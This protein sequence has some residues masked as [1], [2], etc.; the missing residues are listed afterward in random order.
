MRSDAR[1]NVSAEQTHPRTQRETHFVPWDSYG[2]QIVQALCGE[3]VRRHVDHSNDP[4][5]A[6]CR[7]R[8]DELEAM[9]IE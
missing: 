9:Q 4:S 3:F 8:R 5:C 6:I 1:A 2:R 7:A